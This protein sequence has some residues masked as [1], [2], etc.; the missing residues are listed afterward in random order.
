[1][2]SENFYIWSKD[3]FN[4]PISDE[5]QG[6][7]KTVT[8]IFKIPFVSIDTITINE[9]KK[10]IDLIIENRKEL[11]FLSSQEYLN[12]LELLIIRIEYIREVESNY[13]LPEISEFNRKQHGLA[14]SFYL[15]KYNEAALKELGLKN[16][17]TA[18]KELG[19]LLG[20]KASSIKNMRDEFDPYFDNGRKGWYQREL[21]SSRKKIYK[22][23]TPFSFHDLTEFIKR[24]VEFYEESKRSSS[25]NNHD[26]NNKNKPRIKI[27]STEMK[28]INIHRR[29][30]ILGIQRLTL[31]SFFICDKMRTY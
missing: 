9:S 25:S 3:S 12:L 23:L 15:S 2:K 11:E 20:I 10:L 17:S 16:F 22:L 18:F 24:I 26:S 1:M 8:Q 4:R 14:I 6:N 27:Q 31:D 30:I 21:R 29:K 19:N 28:E 7:L 13:K 5:E